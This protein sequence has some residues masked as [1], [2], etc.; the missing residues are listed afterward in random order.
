MSLARLRSH[1]DILRN[2]L[3]QAIGCIYKTGS[4]GSTVCA[5]IWTGF[6]E[7]I[8]FSFMVHVVY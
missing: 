4:D 8:A 3:A 7:L 5:V 1:S 2:C 6:V